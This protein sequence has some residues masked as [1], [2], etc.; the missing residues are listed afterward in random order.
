MCGKWH[1]DVL[2]NRD[3]WYGVNDIDVCLIGDEQ[4]VENDI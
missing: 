1:I 3:E 2:L 4:W